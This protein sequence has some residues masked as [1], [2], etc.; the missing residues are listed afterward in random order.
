M[1]FLKTELY[2]KAHLKRLE[3]EGIP[4]YIA[5]HGDDDAG[6]LIVKLSTLDGKASM[7]IREYNL[8]TS[9]RIWVRI[10]E[11]SEAEVDASIQTQCGF[12]PDLWVLEIEDPK[13]RHFLEN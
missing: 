3:I 1:S 4:A 12:D 9:E 10:L 7:F 6:N 2:I 8:E 5:R 11:A 13:G